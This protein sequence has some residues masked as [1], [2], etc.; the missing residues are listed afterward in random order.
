MRLPTE[1]S[2]HLRVDRGVT[3][4][5]RRLLY[6]PFMDTIKIKVGTLVLTE[7]RNVDLPQEFAAWHQTVRV[8][9]GTYDVFAYL[10]WSDGGY[11][12]HSLSAACE[13]VTISSNFRSHMLGQWGKSDNNCNGQLAT[14]HVRL[15]T[16]GQ[17]GE[18]APLLAQATLCDALVRTE[19]DP[20]DHNPQSTAGRI[21]RLTW[22]PERKPIVI[23]RA[24]HNGGL[25]I[26]AFEDTRRFLVDDVEMTPADAKKL[27]LHFLH[28]LRSVDQLTI[29]ETASGWSHK[30]K[31]SLPVTRL[32]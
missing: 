4:S 16:S 22:N 27:D 5:A 25:S 12:V 31:R 18:S 30:D 10:N 21:W 13:G 8:E 2:P 9:P 6:L 17:V 26:A 29:G 20:R 3:R 24:R 32:A 7:A 14:A 11:R 23:E 19:W 28:I 1:R 15:P